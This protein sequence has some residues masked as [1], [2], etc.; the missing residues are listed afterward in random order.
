M[1]NDDGYDHLTVTVPVRVCDVGGWTD[2]WFAGHG[3]V[4][5]L[6]VGPAVTVSI[7]ATAG[8]GDV[9]IHAA[10]FGERFSLAETPPNHRLLA[11]AV[12]EAEPRPDLDLELDIT[13]AVPPGASVGTSAAVC[14]GVIAAVDA[15]Q[16]TIRSPTR[17]VTAAHRVETERLGRQS[18]VQDQVA[19]AHG[20]ACTIDIEYPSAEFRHLALSPAV[21][22]ALGERLLHVAYGGGHDSSAV[23]ERVIAELEAEG[24]ESPRLARLRLLAEFAAAALVAGDLD[25]YGDALR[26]ATEGQETLHPALVSDQAHGL[27]DLAR[28]VGAAG[29]KVNGAGGEGGSISILCRDVRQHE[30]LAELV[31]GSH[32][33]VLP[34]PLCPHGARMARRPSA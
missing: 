9:R 21:Q 11:E 27:I 4:C 32:G 33:E 30:R 6:A 25:A 31:D 26:S 5:S 1:A 28:S 19:A 20:G 17:L 22:S 14:V 34:L 8:D 10:D 29:W 15:A 23:H 24:P 13:S 16:G 2:T 12:L 18:G 3:R 7:R